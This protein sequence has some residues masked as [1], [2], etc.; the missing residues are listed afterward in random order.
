MSSFEVLMMQDNSKSTGNHPLIQTLSI[1][2]PSSS[3][4]KWDLWSDT[5]LAH[6]RI[7]LETQDVSIL[8]INPA[9]VA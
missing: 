2:S 5:Y 1:S 7:N 6:R 4:K 8:Q 9:L 3:S